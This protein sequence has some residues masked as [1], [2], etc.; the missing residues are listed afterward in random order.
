MKFGGYRINC[1]LALPNLHHERN[2]HHT[3][4]NARSEQIHEHNDIQKQHRDVLDW[5]SY[6]PQRWIG[7]H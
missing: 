1:Y 6:P 4:D 7:A 3:T 2:K 5:K